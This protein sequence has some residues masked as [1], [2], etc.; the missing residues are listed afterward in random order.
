VLFS[1][2]I[3]CKFWKRK[4]TGITLLESGNY[5]SVLTIKERFRVHSPVS[6][7]VGARFKPGREG[8]VYPL[9]M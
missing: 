7:G 3:D 2:E 5:R 4:F 1:S 8:L 9:T 6:I